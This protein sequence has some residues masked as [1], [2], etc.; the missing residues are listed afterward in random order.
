MTFEISASARFEPTVVWAILLAAVIFTAAPWLDLAA[1]RVF[2]SDE[3]GFWMAQERWL[4]DLR[5][6]LWIACVT[7]LWLALAAL[8]G[9]GHRA[10]AV[11]SA[12]PNLGI[13]C[14]DLFVGAVPSGECLAEGALGQGASRKYLGVRRYGPVHSRAAT[15]AGMC[16]Q[17]LLRVR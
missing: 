12:R 17:L 1:S 10:V 3:R 14:V 5:E 4:L 6:V 2:F 7:P 8:I 16:A 9:G 13:R 15:R 11:R